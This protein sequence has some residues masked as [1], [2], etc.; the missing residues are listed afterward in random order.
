MISGH[1]KRVI[2]QTDKQKGSRQMENTDKIQALSNRDN[3]NIH[4]HGQ[5]DLNQKNII[6]V[7]EV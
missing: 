2:G 3:I 1:K 7:D 5:H 4:N 6:L